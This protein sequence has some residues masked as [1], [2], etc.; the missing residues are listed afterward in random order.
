[1]Q[2]FLKEMDPAGYECRRQHS[3]KGRQ[4]INP[5]WIFLGT[6]HKGYD[7]LKPWVFLIH[8]AT[9]GYSRKILWL[10][11]TRINNSPDMIGSLCLQTVGI[12]GSCPITDLETENGLAASIQCLCRNNL[13]AHQ[14][15]SSSRINKLKVGGE[16]FSKI[17]F[18]VTYLIQQMLF[19]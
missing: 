8:G 7:K 10:K 1:M 3:I 19:T 5:G 11:V 18:P 15:V 4:Y 6:W 2:I 12:L 14:Y 13:E 17:W 16:I 9:E